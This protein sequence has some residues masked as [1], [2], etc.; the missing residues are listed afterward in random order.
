MTY[1]LTEADISSVIARF[2][3]RVR[4]DTQLGPVFAVVQ[5]WDDH[6]TRLS[7][8][9][10]SMMLTTGRYKG[11]PLAMH[12]VH[13]EKFRP[14]MFVRWLQLWTQTTDELIPGEIAV[15]MQARAKRIASRFSLMICGEDLPVAADPKLPYAP[16]PYRVSPLFDEKTLP[17]ALLSTH[18]LKAGT[19]GIVRVEEGQVHYCEDG[20]SSPRLLTPSVPGIVPPEV[21]H[22]LELVGPV[23]LR[24]E[25]YDRRPLDTYQ[26]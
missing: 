12:L 4:A 6:L 1:Q 21:P 22:N 11:N 13:A 20:L 2:Y 15:E 10:S 19:W 24:V 17:R 25:F 14:E 8:F 26:H 16:I 7:E 18:A 5:D 9:W 3:E 23:S